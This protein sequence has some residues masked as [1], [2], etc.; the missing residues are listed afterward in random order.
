MSYKHFSDIMSNLFEKETLDLVRQFWFFYGSL[1]ETMWATYCSIHSTSSKGVFES[2]KPSFDKIIQQNSGTRTISTMIVPEFH[3]IINGDAKALN[4]AFEYY[5]DDQVTLK[6]EK[7]VTAVLLRFQKV[8]NSEKTIL[9]K[10]IKIRNKIVLLYLTTLIRLLKDKVQLRLEKK[11]LDGNIPR[12]AGCGKVGATRCGGCAAIWYCSMKCQESHW[13]IHETKC[14]IQA[15]RPPLPEESEPTDEDLEKLLEDASGPPQLVIPRSATIA[16]TAPPLFGDDEKL[17]DARLSEIA[18]KEGY[19]WKQGGWFNT[20][21]K[22]YFI[23]TP[24]ELSYCRETTKEET[25]RWRIPLDEAKFQLEPAFEAGRP[26]AFSIHPKDS[27][28]KFILAGETEEVMQVW[29]ASIRTQL[30]EKVVDQ[31]IQ[32]N[33]KYKKEKTS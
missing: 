6:D 11:V 27:K 30:G 8:V 24:H 29:A 1:F 4:N 31:K 3:P 16:P 21:K 12:C 15:H 13:A 17:D 19:L 14:L 22:R 9:D 2:L 26:Y 23:L 5:Y 7:L 18:V 28:R 32:E 33:F 10:Y 25:K 20:W